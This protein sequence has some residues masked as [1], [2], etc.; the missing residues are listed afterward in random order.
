MELTL[1]N[2]YGDPWAV[3]Q[4]ESEAL[5]R[6]GGFLMTYGDQSCLTL[7]A[8]LS[9]AD[10]ARGREEILD[11]LTTTPTGISSTVLWHPDTDSE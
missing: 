6:L 10:K 8:R 7:N 3:E 11:R 4:R 1:V 2:R 5:T 9:E